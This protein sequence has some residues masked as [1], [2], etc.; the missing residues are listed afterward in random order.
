M[1]GISRIELPVPVSGSLPIGTPGR[2]PGLSSVLGLGALEDGFAEGPVWPPSLRAAGGAES[3]GLKSQWI[4]PV[5][6]EADDASLPLEVA[7]GTLSNAMVI[8]ATAPAPPIPSSP[9][10]SASPA[11]PVV[12][13][14]ACGSPFW[15]AW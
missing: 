15:D 4:D 10:V 6:E 14:P 13:S 1:P 3:S 2:R 7:P 9:P 12:H 5:S 8:G 11:P